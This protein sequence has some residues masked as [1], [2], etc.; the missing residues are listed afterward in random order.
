MRVNKVRATVTVAFE[1]MVDPEAYECTAEE[2]TLEKVQ[3]V[4]GENVQ[5]LVESEIDDGNYEV[6]WEIVE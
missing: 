4:D 3:G 6:A 1:Y 5:M 2:L